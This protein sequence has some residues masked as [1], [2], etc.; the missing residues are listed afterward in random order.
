[1]AQNDTGENLKHHNLELTTDDLA[2]LLK[3]YFDH[4]L[5]WYEIGL[6]LGIKDAKLKVIQ[7]NNQ[8]ECY[9]CFHEMLSEWLNNTSSPTEAQLKK[10]TMKAQETSSKLKSQTQPE[11]P[12]TIFFLLTTVFTATAMALLL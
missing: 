3:N 4:T 2:K 8:H 1:M 10:A 9:S 6:H 5:L 11:E 7:K 12:N